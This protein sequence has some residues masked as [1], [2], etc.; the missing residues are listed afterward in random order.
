[1][2][3]LQEKT[4][5]TEKCKNRKMKNNKIYI[6]GYKPYVKNDIFGKKI[7]LVKQHFLNKKTIKLKIL[8]KK[9]FQ[10]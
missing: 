6:F 7:I 9:N 4:S 1:M 3:T 2:K 10:N 5:K 8:Q